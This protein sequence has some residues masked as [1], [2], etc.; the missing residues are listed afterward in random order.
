FPTKA[1]SG[2]DSRVV[3]ITIDEP[4]LR[5]I[6]Q[7]PIPDTVLAEALNKLK[8][9]NPRNIGLSLYRDLPVSP[10][11]EELTKIF[12][13][14][15]NLIGIEKFVGSKVAPP[16]VLDKLGQV[17][18]ADQVLDGDGKVRR[19]LLS[20]GSS[21]T[22]LRYNLSALLAF[23]YLDKKGITP[24]SLPENPYYKQLGKTI[25]IPFQEN[26]GGYVR[27]D[28]GGFQILLNY[29]G[30]RKD[31]QSFSITDLLK[32]RVPSQEIKNKVVLIG[33]IAESINDLFQTPFS[34]RLFGPPTQMSG[35]TINAN[36]VSQILSGALSGRPMLRVWWEPIEYLWIL[37]WSG[38]GAI[39]SWRWKSLYL[40]FVFILFF[41]P[42]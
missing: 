28:A 40:L 21:K 38:I 39:L 10:G 27:A 19:A 32:D 18:L 36:I 42:R 3:I 8:S 5:D 14:T 25:L 16:P 12:K 17:G 1:S 34:T 30:T 22:K 37:L 4:D 41:C 24:K 7:Y 31:F 26:D 23:D 9:Y 29:H 15:P 11:T 33:S 13:T 2:I 20:I 6:G 35:V